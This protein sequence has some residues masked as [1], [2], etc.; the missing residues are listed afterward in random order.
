MIVFI[1]FVKWTAYEYDNTKKLFMLAVP[2]HFGF[3]RFLGMNVKNKKFIFYITLCGNTIRNTEEMFKY[4]IVTKNKMTIDQFNFSVCLNPLIEFKTMKH[5]FC[6]DDISCGHEFRPIKCVNTLNFIPP[7]QIEYLTSKQPMTGVHL[8]LDSNFLC[9]YDCTDNC[10]DKSKCAYWQMTINE[11]RTMP[12][13]CKNPNIG[14]NNRLLMESV[15]TGIYECN[16]M[17]KCKSLCL[18]LHSTS[19]KLELFLTENKGWVVRCLKDIPQGSFICTYIG[20]LLTDIDGVKEGK[21][22]GDEYLAELDNTEAVEQL[23]E[24]YETDVVVNDDEN[25]DNFI[26]TKMKIG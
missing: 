15:H 2:L 16:K 13:L 17:C 18:N 22:F 3:K 25:S 1:F 10:Q 14:Y 21:K 9:A 5:F 7:P 8:N 4:P 26:D 11:Q 23:K 19:H 24:D 20:N 12:K 6:R